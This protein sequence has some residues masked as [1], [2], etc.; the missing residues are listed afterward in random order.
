MSSYR[1]KTVISRPSG[2]QNR[3]RKTL[4]KE[5]AQSLP[6]LNKFFKVSKNDENSTLPRNECGGKDNNPNPVCDLNEN[7][8]V[9]TVRLCK[10]SIASGS[11]NCFSE[12]PTAESLNVGVTNA[13]IFRQEP[14]AGNGIL[15]NSEVI[16]TDI[17]LYR[18][19]FL[20]NDLR[21]SI[22]FANAPK[23]QGPFPKNSKNR[24]FSVDYYFT[25]NNA[26]QKIEREWLRYSVLL[27]AVYCEA[28]W[29]FGDRTDKNFNDAWCNGTIN[30]WQGL[31]KKIKDHA[32]ATTHLFSC[33]SYDDFK[34]SK[35]NVKTHLT[36]EMDKYRDIL[37]MILDIIV[38]LGRCNIPFEATARIQKT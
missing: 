19:S 2:N 16:N 14:A 37:K 4:E 34:A 18:D 27:D 22:L 15:D 6:K 35:A 13:S 12:V 10:Q 9:S 8:H 5:A 24:S 25:Q 7:L 28:C 23:F 29:L 21:T 20:T 36:K 11:E 26:L 31:S 33:S 3:K 32:G 17:A 38:T 30:D 1:A